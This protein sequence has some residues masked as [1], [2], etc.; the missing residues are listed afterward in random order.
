MVTT[1]APEIAATR[2]PSQIVEMN[3]DPITRIV[4]SLGLYT[5]IDL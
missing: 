1:I 4:G 3:L 5:K 2:K